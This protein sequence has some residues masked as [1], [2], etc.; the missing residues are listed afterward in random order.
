MTK[1]ELEANS[2]LRTVVWFLLTK[3]MVTGMAAEPVATSGEPNS[4]LEKFKQFISSPPII[5]NLI[6]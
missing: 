4:D 6:V 2:S 5:S 1:S 3:L